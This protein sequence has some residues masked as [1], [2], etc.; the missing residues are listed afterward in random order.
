VKL[1]DDFKGTMRMIGALKYPDHSFDVC[2]Q[3][4]VG[5]G[6][7]RPLRW[8]RLGWH[9][10]VF[11]GESRDQ[12]DAQHANGQNSSGNSSRLRHC[13][14]HLLNLDCLE[15]KKR[16]ENLQNVPLEQPSCNE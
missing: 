14:L 15:G 6:S 16:P 7:T 13:D 5:T 11:V 2:C 12:K 3:L 4:A 8:S 9:A 1:F 10:L